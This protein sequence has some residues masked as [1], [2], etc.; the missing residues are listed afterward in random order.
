MPKVPAARRRRDDT[1]P[2]KAARWLV[3]ALARYPA[4]GER[5]VGRYRLRWTAKLSAFRK[6][7]T[8]TEQA[9]YVVVPG[10]GH[11]TGW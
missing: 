4:R 11:S 7:R 5:V 3:V 8:S 9:D 6:S 1:S 2:P 10:P